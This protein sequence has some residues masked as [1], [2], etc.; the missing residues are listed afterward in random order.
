[1]KL[2]QGEK[3]AEAEAAFHNILETAPEDGPTKYFLKLIA[4]LPE[5][6]LPADWTGEV[7]LKEK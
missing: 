7:E 6:P 3:F 2:F 5:H 1:M 4:E